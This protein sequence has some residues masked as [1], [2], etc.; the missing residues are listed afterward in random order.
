VVKLFVLAFALICA[1]HVTTALGEYKTVTPRKDIDPGEV[2]VTTPIR[3]A[4]AGKTYVLMNDIAEP[5]A[6]G[7]K[8][9]SADVRPMIGRKICERPAGSTSFQP[10]RR[11]PRPARAPGPRS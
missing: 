9:L 4:E 2:A 1:T 3:C 8:I 7:A 10:L 5:R 11:A 6:P